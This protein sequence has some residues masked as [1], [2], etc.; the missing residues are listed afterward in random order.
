MTM[1]TEVQL[2]RVTTDD[3][4]H[5]L[6][7]AAASRE[8]AITLA[9]DAVPEGWAAV[10]LTNNSYPLYLSAPWLKLICGRRRPAVS[11]RLGC[12]CRTSYRGLADNARS[13]HRRW[14]RD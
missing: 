7:V 14:L 13:D 4:E 9:L 5:Q 12:E 10:L 6:W 11:G 1:A 2:V 8:E 3:R